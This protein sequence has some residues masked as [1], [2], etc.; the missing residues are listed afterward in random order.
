MIWS[1]FTYSL[2]CMKQAW[3]NLHKKVYIQS[4]AMHKFTY[5]DLLFGP[6]NNQDWTL[7]RI[8]LMFNILSKNIQKVI[9]SII[10]QKN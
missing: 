6:Y 10:L 8:V 9:P 7:G 3:K 1:H 5:C 2:T 4:V